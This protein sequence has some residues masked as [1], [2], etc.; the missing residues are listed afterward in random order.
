MSSQQSN[1]VEMLANQRQLKQTI[2]NKDECLK[3]KDKRLKE[4]DKRI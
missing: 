2:K 4:K 3:E 1:T